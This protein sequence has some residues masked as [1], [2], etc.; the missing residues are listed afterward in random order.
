MDA[1]IKIYIDTCG[2][3]RPFD[4]QDI[5][6][7]AAETIAIVTA[8]EAAQ[9]AGYVIVG[10]LAVVSEL[11]NIKNDL[12]RSVI[13]KYYVDAISE[14]VILSEKESARAQ[15]LQSDGVGVMDSQHLAAAESA[16]ASYLLTV[17]DDF[18]KIVAEKNLSKVNVINPLTYLAGG[19]K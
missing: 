18:I 1:V 9:I 2:W 10:S 5:P 3:C 13:L 6:R 19:I 15:S 14:S 12:I 4:R 11:K 8:I 7:N 16:G 17:D